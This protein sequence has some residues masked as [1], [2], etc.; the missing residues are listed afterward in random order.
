[1]KWPSA[2]IPLQGRRPGWGVTGRRGAGCCFD[3][4][5]AVEDGWGQAERRGPACRSM[6]NLSVALDSCT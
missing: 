4:L 2:E 5:V 6:C 3:S 1:M